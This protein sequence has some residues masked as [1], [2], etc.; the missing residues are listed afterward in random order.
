MMNLIAVCQ[1]ASNLME[2][3]RATDT[4]FVYFSKTFHTLSYNM[5]TDKLIKYRLDRWSVW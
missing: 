2:R 3:M 4:V 1:T 5:L